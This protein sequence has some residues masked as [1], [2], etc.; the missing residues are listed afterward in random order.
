MASDDPRNLL[1]TL[2]D[3]Y[4]AL[5]EGGDVEQVLKLFT[6]PFL[7]EALDTK[8][9]LETREDL[10]IGQ[11]ALAETMRGKGVTQI[12][13][14]ASRA[15]YLSPNYIDGVFVTHLLHDSRPIARSYSN[16]AVLKRSDD[17]WRFSQIT[18]G[19][20]HKVWPVRVFY[21]PEEQPE[22]DAQADD[23]RREALEP[24]AI[25]QS[26][27]NRMTQANVADDKEAY[28]ALCELPMWMH[29]DETDRLIE[30]KEGIYD[31][32]DA[33]TKLLQGY[34]IEDFLRI[35]D[36][37]EFISA[38]EICGYHT[39]HFLRGGEAAVDPIKSRLI[40]RRTGTRW[41]LHSVTNSVKYGEHT[42][43]DPV[44]TK[45]LK[46]LLD[47]QKRTKTWPTLQ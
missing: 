13:R 30:D 16:R 26:F 29:M 42:F 43:S 38:N 32:C 7:H 14:L 40:L 31:F 8:I 17:G 6:L 3:R 22:F 39:A 24:L 21:V 28:L 12:I 41:R 2:L 44:P 36:H 35:A 5:C 19:F 1:Q 37:A 18:Y 4:S 11:M 23:A 33:V 10:R 47:I 46:T 25:Y 45:D 15:D 34:Q 20:S 9:M 27:I